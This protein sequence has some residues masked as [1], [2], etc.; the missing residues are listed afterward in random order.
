MLLLG[1]NKTKHDIALFFPQEPTKAHCVQIFVQ[2]T[3]SHNNGK[4]GKSVYGALVKH[5]AFVDRGANT[6]TTTLFL[7]DM[8][9]PDLS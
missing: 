6:P 1:L 9:P 2:S 3:G 8:D 5:C 4:I 7:A